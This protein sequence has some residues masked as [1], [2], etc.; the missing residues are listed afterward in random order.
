MMVDFS[1]TFPLESAFNVSNYS[2]D[3]CNAILL[4]LLSS[5]A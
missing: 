2:R 5:V 4:D 3:S 1:A